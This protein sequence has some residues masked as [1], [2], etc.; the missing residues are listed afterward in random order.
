M[1]TGRIEAFF[2]WRG[3]VDVA[4]DLLNKLASGLQNMGAPIR[5]NHA[6]RLSIPLATQRTPQVTNV[7]AIQADIRIL[8][9]CKAVQACE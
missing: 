2:H 4:N 1:G 7:M 9:N 6:G 5:R 3:T 8:L